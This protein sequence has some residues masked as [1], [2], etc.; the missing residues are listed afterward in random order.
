MD[1]GKESKVI[2]MLEHGRQ[3]RQMVMVFIYGLKVISM[4]DNGKHV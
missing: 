4:R 1:Y 2:H 3:I